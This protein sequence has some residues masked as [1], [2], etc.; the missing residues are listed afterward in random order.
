MNCNIFIDIHNSNILKDIK[1]LINT[2][3]FTYYIYVANGQHSFFSKHIKQLKKI[4]PVLENVYKLNR[5]HIGH[6]D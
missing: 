4:N 6:V 5:N 2:I 3:N 1:D